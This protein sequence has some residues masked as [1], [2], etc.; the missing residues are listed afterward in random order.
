MVNLTTELQA[1]N[2]LL[3][4]IGE[5]P[6]NTL[7]TAEQPQ[8]A[9]IARTILN[10]TSTTVQSEGWNFNTQRHF[11]LTPDIGGRLVVP[12]NC[13]QI[14]PVA[15]TQHAEV[16]LR[17]NKVFNREI[18]SFTFKAPVW[19]DMIVL[20]DFTELPQTA[21]RYITA[22]AARLFQQRFVGSQTLDTY[23]RE[24]EARARAALLRD[25]ALSAGY[26]MLTDSY[27]MTR[28]LYR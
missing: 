3:A 14:A 21:H 26:N 1:V 13:I 2:V 20:L 16:A 18:N 24:E 11:K 25:D 22:K 6:V 4:T 17:G 8:E 10:E 15:P 5:S 12:N 7:E 23:A 9:V 28:L 19:V 27:T